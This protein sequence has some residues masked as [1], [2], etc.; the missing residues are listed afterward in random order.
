MSS[1][2]T[3]FGC[4][5]GPMTRRYHLRHFYL[6]RITSSQLSTHVSRAVQYRQYLDAFWNNAVI[7]E[8]VSKSLHG[9]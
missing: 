6:S 8:M 3:T 5:R 7:D 9:P 2:R 4:V 1:D